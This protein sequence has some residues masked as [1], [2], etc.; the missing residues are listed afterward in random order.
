MSILLNS[1][2]VVNSNDA[3]VVKYTHLTHYN[4]GPYIT[5]TRP[6]AL[7]YVPTLPWFCITKLAR[8]PDQ[9]QAIGAS[10]LTYHA[11]ESGEEYDILRALIPTLSLLEFNWAAIDPRLW[12]TIVQIYDNLPPVFGCYPI[13]LADEHLRTL[14]SIESTPQ[15]SLVTILELPG[16]R[17]LS[18]ST[19]VNLKYL[20]S[21]C[22]FDASATDVS[23]HALKVFSGTVLWAVDDRTRRG[24]WGLRILRLRN[25]RN[26][27]D[28]IL[29][30][31][32]PF[33]LLSILDLRGTKCHSDTFHPTFQPAPQTK[34]EFYNPTP[35]RLSVALLRS[36]SGL[37][38]SPN[39]FA[40]YIN[41]LHHPPSTERPARETRPTEDVCVTF[42]TGSHFV[43]GTSK[44]APEPVAR[45]GLGHFG[46]EKKPQSDTLFERIAGEE[47]TAHSR[48][49]NVMSFY[50]LGLPV[51]PRNPSRGYTYPPEAPL[52]P[53]G[54]DAQLMLYR[55]PPPWAALEVTT[56]DVHLAKPT[57]APEVVTGVSKRKRGEMAEYARQLTEKRRKIQE[58]KAAPAAP[59]P[60]TVALS[61]NPFRRK[62]NKR[63][64][65]PEASISALKPLKPISSML[66]QPLPVAIT[67]PTSL[68][69]KQIS[70]S[71]F[72]V[73]NK[74]PVAHD[75][76]T[77]NSTQKFSGFDW[78]EWGKK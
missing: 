39:L 56:P 51:T 42:S 16:C 35:L 1:A 73:V 24:P 27:D 17:E 34:Y 18:D 12:A 49:Q 11:P 69:N 53:S 31:I 62:F 21:L 67:L 58:R 45:K 26:I 48:K 10:R 72:D 68:V 25:C 20:H 74:G 9:V 64:A 3:S 33:P 44:E 6:E 13:P 40:L 32:S 57:G 70:P 63:D 29:S 77:A 30:H 66:A 65:T 37:F 22:A 59:A 28:K 60:E 75:R 43:V 8:F 78:G 14:M 4:P 15:F 50:H 46:R 7:Q 76:T 54:K 55:P 5:T 38:S 47:L 23:S 52:P 19:I 2:T 36:E 61:R 41:T 71:D